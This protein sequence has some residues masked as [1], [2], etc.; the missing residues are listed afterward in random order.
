MFLVHCV[1]ARC[2]LL[3]VAT[4][5]VLASLP[6]FLFSFSLLLEIVVRRC[7]RLCVIGQPGSVMFVSAGQV[8]LAAMRLGETCIVTNADENQPQRLKIWWC[9][10]HGA[11]WSLGFRLL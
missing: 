7:R 11:T 6:N 3:S 1:V 8:L 5:D 4:T 9:L 10:R 2:R